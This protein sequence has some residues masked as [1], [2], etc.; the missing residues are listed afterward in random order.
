M[1][2]ILSAF[3]M[4]SVSTSASETF[5]S[6]KPFP[7]YQHPGTKYYYSVN[8][9]YNNAEKNTPKLLSLGNIISQAQIDQAIGYETAYSMRLD[10]H[11]K[12]ID[13][14]FIS[15]QKNMFYKDLEFFQQKQ[16]AKI[17]QESDFYPFIY[18]TE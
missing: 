8:T 14:F 15:R 13:T 17:R 1:V 5:L 10:N 18:K 16:R 12:K 9:Y 4:T 6:E 3:L 7:G 11:L 2:L